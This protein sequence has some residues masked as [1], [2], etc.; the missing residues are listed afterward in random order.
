MDKI[1]DTPHGRFILR[2]YR[3]ED[4]QG[5]L[6]LWKDAFGQEMEPAVWRWK[7][8]DG[9]FGHRIVLCLDQD[10]RVV[11][12][13]PGVPYPFNCQGR[14]IRATHLMDSMSHPKYRGAISGRKG[15]F[16]QT[17]EHYYELYGGDSE[18]AF[19]YGFP[20][21]R[22]HL[23]GKH[24]LGYASL[25]APVLYFQAKKPRFS[26]L[27]QFSARV[28]R[29][30]PGQPLEVFDTLFR[31][32]APNYPLIAVRDAAFIRWRFLD[33]P[34]KCY[35][36]WL[37]SS[38]DG[39]Y[40]G[41]VVT[42]RAEGGVVRIVDALLPDEPRLIRGFLHR[43]RHAL[44]SEALSLEAWLPGQHFLLNSFLEAGFVLAEEPLGIVVSRTRSFSPGLDEA[45][46][47]VNLFY[48]M[49]DGDLF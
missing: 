21:H 45:Y 16:V 38:R 9:P 48:T 22:H 15:L 49:A 10:G 28:A 23:L 47:D 44:R 36:I 25:P 24:L 13:Y 42:T 4:E 46:V 35:H 30:E 2:P 27:N 20:G 5:V 33:H 8:L 29:W 7:Y 37:A 40:R 26:L 32:L 34:T 18:S 17:A 3:P 6:D 41:Y 14:I 43:L 19:M 31:E 39:R 1:L 12:A 11:S